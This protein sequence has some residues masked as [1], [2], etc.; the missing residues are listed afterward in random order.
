[1]VKCICCGSER[2]DSDNM[3]PVCGMPRLFGA[4]VTPEQKAKAVSENKRKYLG[5]TGIYLTEHLYDVTENGIVEAGTRSVLIARPSELELGEISWMPES[6][7]AVPSDR[8]F[9]LEL[10]VEK[11]S[12]RS[13]V[14]V[15]IAPGRVLSHKKL[16]VKLTEGFTFRMV[17]GDE[18]DQVES[19]AL[20]LL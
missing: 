2:D 13:R 1:M 17:V 3:C 14:E 5:N 9:C 12:Q 19:A 16:G 18:N 11:G 20:E 7:E 10:E 8:E 6:Y 4:D 15:T